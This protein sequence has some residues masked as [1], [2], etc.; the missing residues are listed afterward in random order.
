[1]PCFRAPSYLPTATRAALSSAAMSS[2]ATHDLPRRRPMNDSSARPRLRSRIPSSDGVS[3]RARPKSKSANMRR[4]LALTP[5]SRSPPPPGAGVR[6]TATAPQRKLSA[7]ILPS[8]PASSCAMMAG[9]SLTLGPTIASSSCGVTMK[10]PSSCV[11]WR[12]IISSTSLSDSRLNCAN[13]PGRET[14]A[15]ILATHSACC[16]CGAASIERLLGCGAASIERLLAVL[17]C[18]AASGRL[19][20]QHRALRVLFR[21]AFPFAKQSQRCLSSSFSAALVCFNA[22]QHWPRAK[23]VRLGASPALLRSPDGWTGLAYRVGD[24]MW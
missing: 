21:V 7:L 4:A 17:V 18:G 14:E 16:A 6:H 22:P 12:M 20:K 3:A 24:W 1:M 15:P 19:L 2:K 10:A 9:A 5:S 8:S 11:R 13:G 23:F